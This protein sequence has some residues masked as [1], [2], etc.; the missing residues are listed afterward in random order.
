MG[1]LS[2]IH[3]QNF[4]T[5]DEYLSSVNRIDFRECLS[6]I[7]SLLK[8][9]LPDAQEVI[10]YGIPMYKQAGMVIGFAAFKNH[11]S[12]F[13]GH[14]VADFANELSQFKTSKGTVQ[15]QP[16]NPISDDL[17]VQIA[18]FRL[19]ENLALQQSKKPKK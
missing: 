5:V 6:H 12:I 13:P 10:S 14:T 8:Q 16:D 19:A 18:Q 2:A 4:L 9:A 11:C 15:F 1:S 3:M 17:I 7:R